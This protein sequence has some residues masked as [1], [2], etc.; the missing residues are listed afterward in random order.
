MSKPLASRAAQTLVA[1]VAIALVWLAAAQLEQVHER[2]VAK[3]AMETIGTF[4]LGSTTQAQAENLLR[5]Y[6]GFKVADLDN[7]IQL[8]FDNRRWLPLVPP[9]QWI[10]ITVEF[11]DGMLTSR[12]VQLAEAPRR[13]AIVH[14][15]LLPTPVM[16]VER[17]INHRAVLLVG[18]IAEPRSIV[19]ID[20]DAQIPPQQLAADWRVDFGCFRFTSGCSNMAN[21]LAGAHIDQRS[22]N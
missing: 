20:E 14:Q 10:W 8:G 5:S 16:S 11:K 2:L 13:S 18:G 22:W 21:V 6:S 12:S 15:S 9:S 3:S 4:Q 7:G 1:L 17:A 19:R